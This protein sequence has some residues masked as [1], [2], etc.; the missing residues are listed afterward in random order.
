MGYEAQLAA[1]QNTHFSQMKIYKHSKLGHLVLGC[2]CKL[3]SYTRK[4]AHARSEVYEYSDRN[5]CDP[6]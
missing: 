6:G 2:T 1:Q 4:S 3:S 5:L